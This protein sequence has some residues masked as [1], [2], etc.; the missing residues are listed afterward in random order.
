MYKCRVHPAASNHMPLTNQLNKSTMR[1]PKFDSR[2][3]RVL[4]T[5]NKNPDHIRINFISIQKH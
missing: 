3:L 5:A 4:K 1:M 2:N